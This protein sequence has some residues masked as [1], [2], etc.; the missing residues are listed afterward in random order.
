MP[1]A[2]QEKLKEN[3]NKKGPLS[4]MGKKA[5]TGFAGMTEKARR[6]P[7]QTLR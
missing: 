4:N 5:Y 7:R 1:P 2:P 6:P 3:F